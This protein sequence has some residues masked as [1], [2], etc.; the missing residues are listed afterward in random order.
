L[1]PAAILHKTLSLLCI[2]QFFYWGTNP[3]S[4][5]LDTPSIDTAAISYSQFER[6]WPCFE[7]PGNGFFRPDLLITKTNWLN[8]VGKKKPDAQA[9]GLVE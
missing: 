5:A 1:R 3:F 9:A 4:A 2:L 7:K 6:F 8:G